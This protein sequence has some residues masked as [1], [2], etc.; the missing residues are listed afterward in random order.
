MYCKN[1]GAEIKEGAL[2]CGECGEY[3]SVTPE[4]V[5]EPTKKSTK[6]WDIFS[7]VGF[8]GGL[9]CFILSFIPLVDIFAC[10]FAIYFIV[11]SALGKK[12]SIE[13]CRAKAAKGLGFSV[14]ATIIGFIGYII[15]MFAM[16]A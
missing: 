10:S 5:A 3:V 1:C 15:F 6:V 12:S 8:I 16:T 2:Y 7:K 9:V 13:E 14:A 4:V 11:F